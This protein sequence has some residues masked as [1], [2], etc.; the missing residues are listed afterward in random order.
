M[1]RTIRVSAVTPE[2]RIGDLDGNLARV[3][4]A[5]C[6]IEQCG[7][8]LVVLP[9]LATSGYVFADADEAR[10]LAL[11]ADDE[12]LTALAGAVPEGAVTVVGF[13]EVD[14][15]LL[16]NSAIVF[17][18]GRAL[19]CYRKSHLWAA[20]STIFATGPEAGTI[21][22][23]PVCRLGVA[24]CY[25][26]EFPETPRRLALGGAEVLA[27]PVNWPLVPRPDGERAP[28]I[29]QAMAAARSSQLATVIADR[30]GQ[31][32]GVRWTD[33]T[34]VIGADGW[35]QATPGVGEIVATAV[36]ELTGD[37]TI[38][39]FNDVIGDRRPE[40]YGDLTVPESL[41]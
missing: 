18:D 35:I 16:Y 28:E 9:E 15:E 27:L 17:G 1:S 34:A 25:D 19:G 40:L 4:A 23:T 41:D 36:L 6:A 22:D 39:E 29:I 21:I 20:E 8:Q 12:R 24:I 5:L 3:R 37:K 31:E 11:R 7:P 13:C 2:I 30:R 33:G 26:N 38:G 14:G 32:R 10:S